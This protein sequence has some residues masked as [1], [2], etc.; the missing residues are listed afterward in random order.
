MTREEVLKGLEC[1]AEF[2]CG[3]CPYKIY[4][5]VDYKLR[6]NYKLIADLRVVMPKTG[7]WTHYSSTMMECSECKKHVPYHRYAYC[8]HCGSRNEME[9]NNG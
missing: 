5:H 7:S 1:C 6:C 8:P 3:E 9:K 2:L 4:S